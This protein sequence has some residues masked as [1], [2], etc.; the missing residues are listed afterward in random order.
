MYGGYRPRSLH[1]DVLVTSIA[2]YAYPDA[3]WTRGNHLDRNA[4]AIMRRNGK[5]AFVELETGSMPLDRIREKWETSYAGCAD[6]LLV[7]TLDE[8]FRNAVMSVSAAVAHI[9]YFGVLKNLVEQPSDAVWLR[10]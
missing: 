10:L 6:K 3:E 7:V 4:D 5:T 9:A 2:A 8:E 1:H